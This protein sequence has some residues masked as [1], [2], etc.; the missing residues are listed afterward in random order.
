MQEYW[1]GKKS[2]SCVNPLQRPLLTLQNIIFVDRNYYFKTGNP[3]KK[4]YFIKYH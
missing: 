3:F 2:K 4:T 1:L